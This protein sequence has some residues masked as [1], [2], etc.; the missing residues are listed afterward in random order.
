MIKVNS[1]ISV[2]LFLFLLFGFRNA[3]ETRSDNSAE[4]NAQDSKN[5]QIVIRAYH[6]RILLNDS[7]LNALKT[8]A[9]TDILLQR[10][11]ADVIN[12][13][14]SALKASLPEYSKGD[15]WYTTEM[16]RQYITDLS[17][18]YRWTG[19]VRYAAG[20]KKFILNAINFPDWTPRS[21]FLQ[22]SEMT[23]AVALGY[24]WLYNWLDQESKTQIEDAILKFGLDE[25]LLS[26]LQR[27]WN[28]K[29]P[30]NFG[31]VT[32]SSMI[33][34]AVAIG[35]KFPEILNRVIATAVNNLPIP[36]RSYAPDGAWPEGL[37]YWNF[38]TIYACFGIETLQTAIGNDMG[39]GLIPGLSNAGNFP[40]YTLG[41][42]GT[43]LCFADDAT[44]FKGDEP[45]RSLFWLGKKFGNPFFINEEHRLL[46]THK[47]DAMNV[48][49]Y[50]PPQPSNQVKRLDKFFDGSMPLITFRSEWD[51]PQALF[52]GVKGGRNMDEHAHLDM[53]NFELEALGI[54]WAADLGRDKYDL[55]G[56]FD[57]TT[58]TAPRWSYYRCN[59]HS[60]N[61]PMIN[62]KDQSVTGKAIVK[63]YSENS[64]EPYI[65]FDLT[66][67]YQVDASLVTREVRLVSNRKEVLVIDA[68]NLKMQSVIYWGMTTP[69]SIR[70]M[71]RGE[72][73]LTSKGKSLKAKILSP[74]GLNFYSESCEQVAPQA[75]NTG[76]SRLMVK[77]SRP[78]GAT[79]LKILL[80]PIQ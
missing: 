3:A 65:I 34:G 17:L 63:S 11:A 64:A 37:N 38:A 50:A 9:K 31:L 70:I 14:N 49:F 79:T 57:C 40:I 78:V 15:L 73:L 66:S 41:P 53:G 46:T 16:T 55:P 68:F 5:P 35:D 21:G 76:Y 43:R 25:Y 23:C 74:S 71:D 27:P 59:S 60:H 4:L 1:V 20:A 44:Y 7:T 36:L 77:A 39:L 47:A 61:V 72:A 75:T 10:Y 58:N 51:N 48:V 12:S 52:L 29:T 62:N 30:F 32:N 69:A 6:P 26:N 22:C 67:A 2:M 56:Y 8:L 28:T 54:R 19:E 33:I 24:D 13:A 45:T 80:T 18:A 42:N